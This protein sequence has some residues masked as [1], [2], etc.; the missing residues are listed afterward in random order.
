MTLDPCARNVQK[1]GH[2]DTRCLA[3]A[4]WKTTRASEGV[5]PWF[6]HGI[7]QLGGIANAP[8][9]PA[10][11]GWT[12]EPTSHSLDGCISHLR[13]NGQVEFKWYYSPAIVSLNQ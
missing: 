11:H 13:I 12:I 3:R 1:S 2:D 6:G 7:L 9:R 5:W 10:D 8:I 4:T